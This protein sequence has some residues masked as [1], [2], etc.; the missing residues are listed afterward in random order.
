LVGP[1]QLTGLSGSVNPLGAAVLTLAAFLWASGSIYARGARLPASPLLGTG[2]QMIAGGLGLLVLG[3]ISGEWARLDLAAISTR[4]LLGFLYL[5]FFG[6]LVGFAAYTWLLRVAPTTLVST[7]AYVN[8]LV[9]I[10]LGSLLAQEPITLR[11][12]ISTAI[13]L[14]SVALITRT[15]PLP[16]KPAGMQTRQPQ[17]GD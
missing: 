3:T 14:S 12:L 2:M 17:P 8:P 16:K 5:I 11:I 1:T 9:A 13:I 4:S 10:M 15:Q 6:A 7:Y